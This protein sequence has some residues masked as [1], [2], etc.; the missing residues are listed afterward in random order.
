MIKKWFLVFFCFFSHA[1]FAQHTNFFSFQN[2]DYT[3]SL[4]T[5]KD[6]GF[7][8]SG[9]SGNING[10]NF[11]ITKIDRNGSSEWEYHNNQFHIS[12]DSDNVI[13]I[14]TQ[15]LDKGFIGVGYIEVDASPI[16]VDL[17]IVKLDSNGN[18][19]WRRNYNIDPYLES[20]NNVFVNPDSTFLALGWGLGYNLLMKINNQGDTLWTKKIPVSIVSALE[21]GLAFNNGYYLF[22]LSADTILNIAQQKILYVDSLG[23]IQWS[24][25]HSDTAEIQSAYMNYSLSTD[26][27]LLAYTYM[28]TQSGQYYFRVSKYGLQ[29]G[30]FG[31]WITSILGR[32]AGDSLIVGCN[33][34]LP[35]ILDTIHI[36]K[37]NFYFSNYKEFEQIVLSGNSINMQEFKVD[38]FGSCIVAGKYN[39]A[40]GFTGR[41][42]DSTVINKVE[43]IAKDDFLSVFPI[44]CKTILNIQ[45]RQ[46]SSSLS[47]DSIYIY[48]LFGRKLKFGSIIVNANTVLD[49]SSIPS[50]IYFLYAQNS[51]NKKKY[52]VKKIIID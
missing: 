10:S 45:F 2:A 46:E 30:F 17:L 27:F 28:K 20:L 51:L 33:I 12:G 47:R 4:D 19:E 37:E 35:G 50:G 16:N 14:V 26:S 6:G 42:I 25:E 23:I 13:S 41:Y 32:I 24:T 39:Q 1:S 40:I 49:I 36:G 43:S 52:T 38:K 8:V 7:I 44:P 3:N 31:S 15:T 34:N 22:G 11:V 5:S 29:G 48:D 9:G 18:L 21:N